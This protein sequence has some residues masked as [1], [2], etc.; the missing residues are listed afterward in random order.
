MLNQNLYRRL[1]DNCMLLKTHL[2]QDCNKPYPRT[3][4]LT[5]QNGG[6]LP[7]DPPNF[8][9]NVS[10]TELLGDKARICKGYDSVTSIF[11]MLHAAGMP[12]KL[13]K[14]CDKC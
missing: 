2:T 9:V 11:N 13:G 10:N 1:T 5:Q 6:S 12:D 7:E 14:R 4:L 3:I 8:V